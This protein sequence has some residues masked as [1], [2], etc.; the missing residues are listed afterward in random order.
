[1]LIL[2]LLSLL[3]GALGAKSSSPMSMLTPM[4]KSPSSAAAR[5]KTKAKTKDT[6]KHKHED[7]HNFAVS[8]NTTTATAPST[9]AQHTPKTNSTPTIVTTFKAKT[10]ETITAPNLLQTSKPLEHACIA[11]MPMGGMQ[12]AVM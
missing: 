4:C 9:G 12:C 11:H 3:T 1:M 7:K 10:K 8:H 6:H 5:H 2:G